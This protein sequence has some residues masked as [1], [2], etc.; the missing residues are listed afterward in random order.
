M[1]HFVESFHPLVY[2]LGYIDIL[3]TGLLYVVWT[4]DTTTSLCEYEHNETADQNDEGYVWK[5]IDVIFL[6][7][8]VDKGPSI[9]YVTRYRGGVWGSGIKE[10][11]WVKSC[12]CYMKYFNAHQYFSKLPFSCHWCDMNKIK[13]HCDSTPTLKW[14]GY[15]F[16]LKS[17]EIATNR[18]GIAN[19]TK[20]IIEVYCMKH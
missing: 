14:S 11:W 5:T 10:R 2:F 7:R 12:K 9:Y 16:K 4:L 3:H 19:N 17:F 8:Q 15:Y 1:N 13:K 20:L 18:F 6:A